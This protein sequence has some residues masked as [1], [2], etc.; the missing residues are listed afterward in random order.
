MKASPWKG[1]KNITHADDN[2]KKAGAV[3]KLFVPRPTSSS[4]SK[5]GAVLDEATSSLLK[6]HIEK[7]SEEG[8]KEVET[9]LI[10][11]EV[12][13]GDLAEDNIETPSLLQKA[14]T[15]P[16]ALEVRDSE[17]GFHVVH[18]EGPKAKVRKWKC[19][20]RDRTGGD[21]VVNVCGAK[22]PI[23]MEIDYCDQ[24]SSEDKKQKVTF[25]FVIGPSSST[26][27]VVGTDQP[28]QAL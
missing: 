1:T 21:D 8:V 24:G 18:E 17:Q 14:M 25:N 3:K 22:R 10:H 5:D 11:M 2:T 19:I 12:S 9:N 13:N 23:A 6:V 15:V 20:A 7:D 26:E 4:S 28:R 27:G 16:N